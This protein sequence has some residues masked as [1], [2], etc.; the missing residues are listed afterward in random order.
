M[1]K[2]SC[3]KRLAFVGL[4]LL[5]LTGRAFGQSGVPDGYVDMGV[6]ADNGDDLYWAGN[7]L[8]LY[9]DGSLKYAQG[10]QQGSAIDWKYV[11][12][13]L[14]EYYG[15][16]Y[17]RFPRGDFA[18]NE[19]Y[20]FVR[21]KL[22][23]PYRLPTYTEIQRMLENST[24]R[25]ETFGSPLPEYDKYGSP[26]WLYGQWMWQTQV[27]GPRG[28]AGGWISIQFDEAV[29]N[30]ASSDKGVLYEGVYSYNKESQTVSFG[31]YKLKVKSPGRQLLMEGGMNAIY[32]KVS[33]NT[34]AGQQTYL[35]ITSKINGNWLRIALPKPLST[36]GNGK[37]ILVYKNSVW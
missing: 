20:D 24:F 28:T 23:S 6:R 33:D 22:G 25:V 36:A 15:T 27:R 29:V 9:K 16:E 5:G 18:G 30:M 12:K 17:E 34:M 2:L 1:E 31:G 11:A 19:R 3:M 32:E 14:G 8:V 21:H 13:V 10:A 37:G 4:V 26:T 7:D 35:T